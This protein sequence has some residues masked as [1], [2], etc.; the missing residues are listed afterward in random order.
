MFSDINELVSLSEYKI[1][2]ILSNRTEGC[3]KIT[4]SHFADNF[5]LLALFSFGISNFYVFLGIL[6]AFVKCCFNE[7]VA[8]L[9][10]ALM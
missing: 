10:D 1:F 9:E 7:A 6:S 8:D 2:I 4:L 5:H 3:F